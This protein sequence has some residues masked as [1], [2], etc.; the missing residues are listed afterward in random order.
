MITKKE[1]LVIFLAAIIIGFI[2]ISYGLF[3]G[4]AINWNVFGKWMVCGLIVVA[5]HILG[6]KICAAMFDSDT[7]TSLWK[8]ERFGFQRE[9]HFRNAVPAGFIVPVIASLISFGY[10]KW[11]FCGSVHLT[12]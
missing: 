8:M 11:K 7:E 10:F 9:S 5:A 3:H 4:Q 12:V 6:Q 2:E 1:I